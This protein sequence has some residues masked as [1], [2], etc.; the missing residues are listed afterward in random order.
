MEQNQTR[1]NGSGAAN[2][3]PPPPER[4]VSMRDA[5]G[6]SKNADDQQPRGSIDH[7]DSGPPKRPRPKKKKKKTME[8]DAPEP[9]DVDMANTAGPSGPQAGPS[10]SQAGDGDT[11]A[12]SKP[13]PKPKAA[14]A[15][16]KKRTAE[17]MTQD[18]EGTVAGSPMTIDGSI[19]PTPTAAARPKP[20]KPTKKQQEALAKQQAADEAAAAA[21]AAQAEPPKKRTNKAPAAANANQG[22][23]TGPPTGLPNGQNFAN[24]GNFPDAGLANGQMFN[25]P[26]MG[27]NLG[28]GP[29]G[30]TEDDFLAAAEA[31]GAGGLDP[32][33]G[34]PNMD[35]APPMNMPL[36]FQPS[37]GFAMT[38]QMQQQLAMMQ[39]ASAGIGPG[40]NLSRQPGGGLS[41]APPPG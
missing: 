7:G 28:S 13:R 22:G 14:A 1:N 20:K 27:I 33:Q 8:P 41:R 29:A 3:P 10:G 2:D 30:I 26:P 18:G 32:G 23:L 24:G 17:E 21:A 5:G 36:Q 11:S 31:L 16:A 38:E 34:L 9:I 40:P 6:P 25:G 35:A 37:Q 15:K 12:K 39:N 19:A 4:D